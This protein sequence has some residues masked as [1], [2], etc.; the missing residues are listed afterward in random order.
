VTQAPPTTPPDRRFTLRLFGPPALIGPDGETVLG[1]H[2]HQHRR[3]AL[4]AAVAAGGSAG[5]SRDR[6]LLLF[7]PETRQVQARHALEQML[8]AI[9]GAVDEAV[10]AGVNPVTLNHEVVR[11]DLAQFTDALARG[12]NEAAVAAY[13]GPFLDGFQLSDAPEFEHWLDQERARLASRYAES[14][15]ELA[16]EA[17]AAQDRAAAVRW[18]RKLAEHDPVSA[19]AA[20]GLIRSLMNA[21]DHA[22]ALQFAERYEEL[23]ARELGTSVGP[24]VAGL[25]NEVRAEASA[26]R[27][28]PASHQERLPGPPVESTGVPGNKPPI[29]RHIGRRWLPITAA[30]AVAAVL[31]AVF[32]SGSLRKATPP[33]A[34]TDAASI[35]VVPLRNLSES[36]GDTVIADAMT[37][38]LIT[39]L[40]RIDRL[41]VIGSTSS[42]AFRNSALDARTIAKTLQVT[43]VLEGSVQRDGERVRVQVRLVDASDGA[44]PWS[45]TMDRSLVDF[46]AVQTEIAAAVAGELDLRLVQGA[47]PGA[48][49]VQTQSI[50][51]S[52]L[53]LRGRD[54]AHLRSDTG[55]AIGLDQLQ[56]AVR[57]DSGFAAAYAAMPYLYFGL[58]GR[59]RTQE[60]VLRL[61]QQ[62]ESTARRAIALDPDLP[63]AHMGLGVALIIGNSDLAGS[64]RAL[65]HAIELGAPPRAHENLARVLTWSGR[66]ADGLV[67][68][69]RAARDDPLS[70][71]AAADMGESL[72]IN[73]RIEEGLV[74][75]D[76]LGT[77]D[78]PLQRVSVYRAICYALQQRW[79]DVI[80]ELHGT[81][82]PRIPILFGYAT[83]RSAGRAR[84]L[85]LRDTAIADWQRTG[86]G[87]VRIA[88]IWAGLDEPD[89]AFAWLDRSTEE[90]PVTGFMLYPMFSALHADPRFSRF[91]QRIGATPRR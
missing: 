30:L 89:S 84:A 29:S 59:V 71:T 76:R 50:A 5:I 27:L 73:G 67:E 16:K 11:S 33:P 9:R 32:P 22:A 75:L 77:L 61:R 85:E 19:S 37:E 34:S 47:Q 91:R 55:L 51:A 66:H 53:F 36:P 35:A 81:G 42:F 64:E 62:A 15:A 7:W 65:R 4:V 82:D 18:W 69:T 17:E 52:E 78:I 45:A 38:Q 28:D 88:A 68:A 86:K 13:G 26:V 58:A 3:L 74:A 60:D 12:D 39:A 70:A 90:A 6:L 79:T 23:V 57:L 1:K 14:V 72:C 41:R 80:D 25:V 8:Y 21:G 43:H 63:E 87:A 2:G 44:A 31:L 49:R 24:A 40:T 54:P 83:A 20:T 56:Q 48:Q 46:F 10:F